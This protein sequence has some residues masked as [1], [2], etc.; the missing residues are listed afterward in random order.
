MVVEIRSRVI[1]PAQVRI[2]TANP[3][4]LV[5]TLQYNLNFLLTSTG[6]ITRPKGSIDVANAANLFGPL[7]TPCC[8]SR[9]IDSLAGTV[10]RQRD[11]ANRNQDR[12]YS[13]HPL[14]LTISS[15]ACFNKL[16][17]KCIPS[18]GIYCFFFRLKKD[19]PIVQ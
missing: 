3:L 17:F 16:I 1:E 18:R 5:T 12:E 10:G 15:F 9:R 8:S 13:S 2:L 11:F 4:T 7:S 14:N 6:G 19:N